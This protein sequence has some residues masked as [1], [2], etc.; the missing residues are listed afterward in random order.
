[1]SDN[2][3]GRFTTGGLIVI[4]GVL[5]LLTTTDVIEM[6]T[7]WEWVP[8]IFVLLGVWALVWS[9][10]R[11]LVGPVMVIAIA[12]AFLLRNLGLLPDGTISTWWPLFVVLFGVLLMVN[13]SRRRQRVRLEGVGTASETVAIAIFGSDERRLRTEQFTGGEIV[14]L[15]GGAIIDLRDA[16]VRARPAVIEAVAIFGDAEIRVPPEWDV[17]LE[18]LNLL[19]DTTDRRPEPGEPRPSGERPHLIVTGLSLFGDIDIRD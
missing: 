16:D 6:T 7:V 10:F 18:T 15:F 5:L 14:S 3:V 4:I 11:N 1:M 13:R 17:R 9:E 8:L 2:L 12:G 19:G